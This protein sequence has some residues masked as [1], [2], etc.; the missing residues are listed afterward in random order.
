M[1]SSDHP[2]TGLREGFLSAITWRHIAG[3]YRGSP[4]LLRQY[5]TAFIATR[6]AEIT[7]TV[8]ELGGDK[9]YSHAALFP[10]AA[11]FLSTNVQGDYDR[12]LDVT[13]MRD[14]ADGSQDAYLCVS[15][16]EHVFEFRKAVDEIHRT[17]KVGGRL[18]MVVPFAYPYHDVVDC[19]RLNRDA[20]PQLFPDF[21]IVEL[22]RLGGTFSTVADLLQRPRGV[23]GKRFLISKTIG[24][25]VALL[26]RYFDTMDGLPLGYGLDAVK[27]R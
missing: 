7:G 23:L 20:Y 17:L 14:V 25:V 16:L 1:T 5:Q 27:R 26:G 4:S 3:Y 15:V 10:H 6:G 13:D 21:E 2:A 22:V 11:G 12:Y 8:V 18:L 19:W 24:V 9:K